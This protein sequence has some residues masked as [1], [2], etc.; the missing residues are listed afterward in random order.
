MGGSAKKESAGLANLIALC[1]SGT[2][3][4]HGWVESNR[5]LA[6]EQGLIVRRGGDPETIPFMDINNQWWLINHSGDKNP[7]MG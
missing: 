7:N 1:G 3:G 5:S 6:I 4:C 2:T